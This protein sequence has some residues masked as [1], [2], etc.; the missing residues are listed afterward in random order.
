MWGH[1]KFGKWSSKTVEI[2]K[3]IYRWLFLVSC[4]PLGNL[5]EIWSFAT[6]ILIVTSLLED[7]SKSRYGSMHLFILIFHLLVSI[8]QMFIRSEKFLWNWF[9]SDSGWLQREL[10][11]TNCIWYLSCPGLGIHFFECPWKTNA[12]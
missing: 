5:L 6:L 3:D 7:I 11:K 10:P 4:F 2:M 8:S 9:L 1:I 12:D